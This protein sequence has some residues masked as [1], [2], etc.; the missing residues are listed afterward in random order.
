MRNLLSRISDHVCD[1]DWIAYGLCV[2]VANGI[3]LLAWRCL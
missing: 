2:A 1:G 3:V